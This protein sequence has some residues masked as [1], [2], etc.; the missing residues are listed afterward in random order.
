MNGFVIVLFIV[1]ALLLGFVIG[2][3]T[4]IADESL[5]ASQRRPTKR[6]PD[7]GESAASQTLFPQS[8]ESTP[9]VDPAATQRR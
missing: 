3:K 1:A 4:R 5:P 8:G 9:E 2:Y 7:A 6:A